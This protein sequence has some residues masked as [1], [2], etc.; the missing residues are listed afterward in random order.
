MSQRQHNF[1]AKV[2]LFSLV[3][4]SKNL[5]AQFSLSATG[6]YGA[7]SQS[8][9]LPDIESKE[10][11]ASLVVSLELLRLPSRTLRLGVVHS[12]SMQLSPFSSGL[13]YTLAT[14]RTYFVGMP[15]EP[16]A[17]TGPLTFKINGISGYLLTG[18]GLSQGFVASTTSFGAGI[19]AGLGVDWSFGNSFFWRTEA[20]LYRSVYLATN[21]LISV[22]S[23][24]G[25][26]F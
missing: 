2:A 23:G 22:T 15:A 8:Y 25:L 14:L 20:S 11:P 7:A 18:V 10:S 24:L 19:V 5:W 9:S 16:K 12:R 26:V 1:F 17:Q 13:A 21:N 4:C 6:G 3:L